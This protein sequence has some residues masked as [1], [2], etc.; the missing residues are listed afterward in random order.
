MPTCPKCGSDRA[1]PVEIQIPSEYGSA[2]L[3]VQIC[4]IC[5]ENVERPVATDR[6][7]EAQKL[8]DKAELAIASGVPDDEVFG[9]LLNGQFEAGVVYGS[10]ITAKRL[11]ERA[12]FRGRMKRIRALW[13]LDT[14][15]KTEEVE[16]LLLLGEN[17]NGS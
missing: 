16:A 13:P 14:K 11:A 6:R 1:E 10:M 5:G 9:L 3:V 17:H 7:E 12:T 8:I 2:K 4:V 15:E